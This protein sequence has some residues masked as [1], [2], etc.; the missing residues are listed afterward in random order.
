MTLLCCLTSHE[1]LRNHS[2]SALTMKRFSTPWCKKSRRPSRTI[3]RHSHLPHCSCPCSTAFGS[4]G[5]SPAVGPSPSVGVT[6]KVTFP[7]TLEER[8]GTTRYP[9]PT[10][11]YKGRLE[12]FSADSFISFRVRNVMSISCQHEIHKTGRGAEDTCAP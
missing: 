3:A 9:P 4:R 12:P 10:H 1:T 5:C 2:L 8:K 7:P 6:R 11:Y